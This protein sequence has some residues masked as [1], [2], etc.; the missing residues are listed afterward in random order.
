[1]KITITPA[2]F[3]KALGIEGKSFWLSQ[4]L[5]AVQL[6]LT[7]YAR[8]RD[9]AAL[10]PKARINLLSAIYTWKQEKPTEFDKYDAIGDGVVRK[11]AVQTGL[12][13]YRPAPSAS[14]LLHGERRV[15]PT[16]RAEPTVTPLS[17]DLAS[18]LV[19]YARRGKKVAVLVIDLYGDDFDA[20]GMNAHYDGTPATVKDHIQRL[21]A[22]TRADLGG[23]RF[24]HLPVY[25]CCKTTTA[26]G[27][28]LVGD[29]SNA[30]TSCYRELI[31]SGTNS[32]LAGTRLVADMR[33][34]GISD[35]F[36]TGF[37]ANMCVAATI[38]GT[39][40]KG[41]G[42]TPGLLDHGFNVLTS[43]FVLASG[44]R[45]LQGNDGWPYMG[46]CN[47]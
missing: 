14:V 15:A 17:G 12:D 5:K 10:E 32:V 27:R 31:I 34:N 47:V 18:L 1:M 44:G 20:Q 23:G 30:V 9:S 13:D 46:R 33:E 2:A 3:D 29:F 6:A 26:K 38:F 45:A 39:G 21:L 11:L 22:H 37:D 16:E 40:V 35:V 24:E 4:Q 42:Y 43:R 19:E 36:A 41:P 25:I 8:D 7:D 28:E